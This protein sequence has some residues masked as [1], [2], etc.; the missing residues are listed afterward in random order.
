MLESNA[1]RCKVLPKTWFIINR[2]GQKSIIYKV[3]RFGLEHLKY[4]AS[5]I[6]ARE[7][8]VES[9]SALKLTLL[10]RPVNQGALKN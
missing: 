9:P 8:Q 6:F 10:V 5:A 4:L 7:N 3:K 2:R 1:I